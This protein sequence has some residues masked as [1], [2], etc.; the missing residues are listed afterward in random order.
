MNFE[1]ARDGGRTWSPLNVA[2]SA[3]GLD[4]RDVLVLVN[5]AGAVSYPSTWR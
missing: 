4:W 5:T 3:G 1:P 2:V